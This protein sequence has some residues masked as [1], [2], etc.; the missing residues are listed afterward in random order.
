MSTEVPVKVVIFDFDGTLADSLPFF[1]AT[2]AEVADRHGFRSFA[3]EELDELRSLSAREIMARAGVPLWKVPAIATDFRRRMAER[4]GEIAL[5]PGIEEALRGLQASGVRIAI[6]TSNS[7]A[8]VRAVLGSELQR[9]VS[10]FACGIALFGKAR[11]LRQIIRSVGVQAGDAILVGDEL[12]DLEAAR[13][14]GIPFAAVS[15]GY[16]EPDALR[17]AGPDRFVTN[18]EDLAPI[19]LS[20]ST[21]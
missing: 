17:R 13:S 15:W 12:R 18:I 21:S 10:H 5:F 20:H 8:N 14:A 16:T 1:R 4:I 6:A 7:E 19:L 2:F 11:K 9:T 3:P